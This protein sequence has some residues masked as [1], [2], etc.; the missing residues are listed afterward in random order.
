MVIAFSLSHPFA[1]K[2]NLPKIETLPNMVLHTNVHMPAEVLPC[3]FI[4][5]LHSWEH[6]N[7]KDINLAEQN[8]AYQQKKISKQHQQ[9]LLQ[10]K[11]AEV[12]W[13][14]RN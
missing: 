14:S 9:Q 3:L 7:I 11:V 4:Y 12:I 10:Q 1:T 13:E 5:I 8:W 2:S 6:S